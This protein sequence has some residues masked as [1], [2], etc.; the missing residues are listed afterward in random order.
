[1][2][3][4][5]RR[6]REGQCRSGR[7]VGAVPAW[8]ASATRAPLAEGRPK[9]STPR[10]SP[11][12]A[13]AWPELVDRRLEVEE[14]K[15]GATDPQRPRNDVNDPKCHRPDVHRSTSAPTSQRVHGTDRSPSASESRAQEWLDPSRASPAAEPSKTRRAAATS[16]RM[17]AAALLRRRVLSLLEG[18]PIRTAPS[19]FSTSHPRARAGP[20]AIA[21]WRK[22]ATRTSHCSQRAHTDPLVRVGPDKGP[23]R[24]AAGAKE[25]DPSVDRADEAGF[26]TAYR[27]RG[28]PPVESD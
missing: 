5:S 16:A 19:C 18:H 23:N 14:E 1:L 4:R 7:S 2:P 9:P 15:A 27:N 20:R 24:R 8:R 26:G 25:P 12:A 11:S 13:R 17:P 22:A 10:R 6:T 21:R 3:W 28:E